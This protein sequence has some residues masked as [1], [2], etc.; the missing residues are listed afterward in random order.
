M[1][2]GRRPWEH[3]PPSGNAAEVV[4][5]VA[6]GASLLPQ[7]TGEPEKG[8]SPNQQELN[9]RGALKE[10]T[11]NPSRHKEDRGSR[12]LNIQHLYGIWTGLTP[13][14]LRLDTLSAYPEP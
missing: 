6:Q 11:G 9:P 8:I 4:P 13:Y 10:D 2:P 1:D 14:R 5:P 3:P 7:V 12:L